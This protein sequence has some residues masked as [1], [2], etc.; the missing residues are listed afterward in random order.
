MQTLLFYRLDFVQ[1]ENF[2]KSATQTNFEG[3]D[4][5]EIESYRVSILKVSCVYTSLGVAVPSLSETAVPQ[6]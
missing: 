5:F 2:N 3:K 4:F 1:E 6:V